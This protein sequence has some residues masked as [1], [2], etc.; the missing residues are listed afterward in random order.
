[1]AKTISWTIIPSPTCPANGRI[2]IGTG[3][4]SLGTREGDMAN[5]TATN[6]DLLFQAAAEQYRQNPSIVHGTITIS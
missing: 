2:V 6:G 3:A 1:M 4:F 5:Y